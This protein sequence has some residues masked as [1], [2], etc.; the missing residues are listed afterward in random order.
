MTPTGNVASSEAASTT[1]EGTLTTTK[2]KQKKSL[3]A[4]AES[5]DISPSSTVS[6]GPLTTISLVPEEADEGYDVI[7]SGATP[8]PHLFSA[9]ASKC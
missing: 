4:L 6:S 1:E 2:K 7:S 3:E 8:S 9:A 5:A